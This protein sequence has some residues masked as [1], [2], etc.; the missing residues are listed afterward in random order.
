MEWS[1]AADGIR[2]RWLCLNLGVVRWIVLHLLY[3]ACDFFYLCF[4]LHYGFIASDSP[5]GFMSYFMMCTVFVQQKSR[6]VGM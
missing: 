1:G 3:F 5:D 4:A 6:Y 2:G